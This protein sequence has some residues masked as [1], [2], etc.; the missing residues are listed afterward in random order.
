MKKFISGGLVETCQ[1]QQ[2]II[3]HMRHELI[4]AGRY[5]HSEQYLCKSWEEL[6]PFPGTKIA[7]EALNKIPGIVSLSVGRYHFGL[8]KA[9]AFT[10]DELLPKIKLQLSK[11]LPAT[12][13]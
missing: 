9:P 12:Y 10:W 3:L 8:T 7:V 13:N 1:N 2:H 5:Y 4:P 11:Y 6:S